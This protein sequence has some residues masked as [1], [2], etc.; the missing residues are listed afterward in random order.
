MVST[1]KN[2][3]T[4]EKAIIQLVNKTQEVGFASPCFFS[5]WFCP[6][7]E[8]L[9]TIGKYLL[10]VCGRNILVSKNQS[11]TASEMCLIYVFTQYPQLLEVWGTWANLGNPSEVRVQAGWT[12]NLN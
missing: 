2:M 11:Q 1:H 8:L 6:P 10:G 4:W 12:H 3:H 7:A 9:P 5:G